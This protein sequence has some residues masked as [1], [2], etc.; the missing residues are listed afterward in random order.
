MRRQSELKRSFAV[1][2]LAGLVSAAVGVAFVPVRAAPPDPEISEREDA[3]AS[4]NE[5]IGRALHVRRLDELFSRL[6]Q[7]GNPE[8][9]QIQTR[10]W[11]TWAQSGSASMDLLLQRAERAMHDENLHA[12][13]THLNDLVRLAPDFAEGWNKRATVYFLQGE[14]GASVADIRRTLML[15]PRHFG[16]L[17]GLGLILERIGDGK[18]ALQAYRRVVEI[19]PN[20]ENAREA[21]E[22]LSSE[23]EGREL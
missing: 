3:G 10:I 5:A 15:E 9:L 8:W 1:A 7:P 11:A 4:E 16:A 23:I 21:V 17:S 14:Y 6:A 12:A 2:L 13:L 22:R 18:G 20:M 19:H